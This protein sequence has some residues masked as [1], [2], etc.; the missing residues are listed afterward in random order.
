MSSHPEPTDSAEQ[1]ARRP[2]PGRPTADRLDQR[3][4][5]LLD[6][7]FEMFLEQGF[8]KTTIAAIGTSIGMTKRTVYRWY[9][10]K[11]TL[12][13]AALHHAISQW[14]VPIDQL[15]AAETADLEESLVAIG[16]MLVRNAVSPAGRRLMR[17][18]SGEA[19]HMPEIGAYT[20]E[21]GTRQTTTYLADLFR[22]S[23]RPDGSDMP[24][25]EAV[26]LAFLTLVVGIPS[27]SVS[28]GIPV[29]EAMIETDTR[30]SVH[31]FLHG[32]LHR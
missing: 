13:K 3:N 7:A 17:I 14:I 30:R 2:G 9:Q 21:Y 15:R 20:D 8:E 31:L 5:E 10:D 26:A 16:E 4:G 25:A 24:D 11:A 18:T 29:D 23:A 32:L 19:H 12:F 1:A 6:R 28:W 27:R 22:R